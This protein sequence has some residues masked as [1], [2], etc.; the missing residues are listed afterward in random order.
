MLAYVAILAVMF[1]LL[2][3][4]RQWVGPPYRSESWRKRWTRLLEDDE[5]DED[6]GSRRE[7]A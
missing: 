2:M 7:D 6:L 1:F 4:L 3:G 5:S